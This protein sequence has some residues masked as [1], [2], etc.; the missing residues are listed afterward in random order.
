[1]LKL[2][3]G[4][5]LYNEKR[6]RGRSICWSCSNGINFLS[7]FLLLFLD[8][9]F[10]LFFFELLELRRSS[11]VSTIYQSCM[12]GFYQ[13]FHSRTIAQLRDPHVCR[14]GRACERRSRLFGWAA[15]KQ[16]TSWREHPAHN[17][18]GRPGTTRWAASHAFRTPVPLRVQHQCDLVLVRH[19]R[20]RVRPLGP[21][22]TDARTKQ[23]R[24]SW[25]AEP[26]GSVI[27]PLHACTVSTSA[28]RKPAHARTSPCDE[29]LSSMLVLSLV[30]VQPTTRPKASIRWAIKTAPLI[31][32]CSLTPHQRHR[33]PRTP[34]RGGGWCWDLQYIIPS[35]R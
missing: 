18:A 10:F 13:Q 14:P 5:S 22:K 31:A 4:I 16:L 30:Q 32:S 8:P 34:S 19:R 7:L 15:A 26:C 1:M 24:S 25:Q 6:E 27:D 9:F 28:S 35:K 2:R 11:S 12:Q 29:M 17:P 3:K 21:N 33:F 20:S 23:G